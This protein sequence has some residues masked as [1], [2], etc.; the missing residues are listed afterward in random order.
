MIDSISAACT[1]VASMITWVLMMRSRDN[2]VTGWMLGMS[3][4]TVIV[5]M[6]SLIFVITK[7]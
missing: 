2:E 4:L 7:W 1:L 6:Y 3:T 5:A